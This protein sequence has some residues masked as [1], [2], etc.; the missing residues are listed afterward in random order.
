MLRTSGTSA[1]GVS[2]GARWARGSQ[3]CCRLRGARAQDDYLYVEYESGFF[4]FKDDAEFWFPEGAPRC[5]ARRPSRRHPKRARIRAL[6]MVGSSDVCV[7]FCDFCDFCPS[8]FSFPLLPDGA[9]AALRA[10]GHRRHSCTS[11]RHSGTHALLAV[12]LAATRVPLLPSSFS[13]FPQQ[14]P[15]IYSGWQLARCCRTLPGLLRCVLCK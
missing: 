3:R 2:S 13:Q 5:P 10:N 1:G 7:F 11:P 15:A 8:G 9:L 12:L 4:G 6:R 14:L